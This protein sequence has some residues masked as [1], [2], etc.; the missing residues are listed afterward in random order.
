M[1][2]PRVSCY[3]QNG[4]S[5]KRAESASIAHCIAERVRGA[6]AVTLYGGYAMF[7]GGERVLFPGAHLAE[8]KRNRD[9]RVTRSVAQYADGSRLVFTWSDANGPRYVAHAS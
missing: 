6:S 7:P 3:C 5:C 1:S 4:A 8:E 9:G 2:A